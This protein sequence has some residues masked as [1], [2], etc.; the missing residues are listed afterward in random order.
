MKLQH[1]PT[2]RCEPAGIAGERALEVGLMSNA[3]Y[4]GH[5]IRDLVRCADNHASCAEASQP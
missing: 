2:T 1:Q 3:V 5:Q 4:V